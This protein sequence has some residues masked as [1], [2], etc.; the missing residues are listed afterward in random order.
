MNHDGHAAQAPRR[1]PTVSFA[2]REALHYPAAQVDQEQ[3]KARVAEQAIAYAREY[4][5]PG[6]VLGVGTGT[7]VNYFID[8]LPLLGDLIAS[9]VASSE[10]TAARL[11][12]VGCRVID[13]NQVSG[14]AL[15]VDGADEADGERRLVKGGGGALTREKIV[16]S[17]SDHFVCVIDES[18]KKERLGAF[19]LAVEVLP[20][21]WQLVSRHLGQ[22][23]GAAELR[24]AFVSDQG[25]PMIDVRGLDFSDPLMLESEINQIPGVVANGLFVRRR[26]DLVMIASAS[27]ISTY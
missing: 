16:A 26:A 12:G 10:A 5:V 6:A 9:C 17:A 20:M 2:N 22:M 25:N 21:A 4:L 14:V 15:Y 3:L 8:K 11:R 18:K 27:G 13:L 19:P 23:G 24:P 7:T 1:V